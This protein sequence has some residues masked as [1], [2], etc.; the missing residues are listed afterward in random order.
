MEREHGEFDAR[1][2]TD[3]VVDIREVVLH[4]VLRDLPEL[5]ERLSGIAVDQ[6]PASLRMKSA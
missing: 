5:L 6:R 4:R 2:R 3:L 1:R